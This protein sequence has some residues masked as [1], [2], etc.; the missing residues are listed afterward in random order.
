M[1]VPV[2]GL[3]RAWIAACCWL[4]AGAAAADPPAP[5]LPAAIAALGL[6]AAQQR[7]WNEG[8]A[9]ET[10]ESFQAST[11]RYAALAAAHPESVFLA[12]RIARNHW[13]Y[14]ERLP[15]DAKAERREAFTRS[16]EWAERALAGDPEC[17]ECVFWT[18]ASMGRL[19]TTV[20][21]VSSARMAAPIAALIDRGIA[22]HPTSSDNE[23]NHTMGNLY[24][25][26]S[27]Y[28]RLLPEW[29][30]LDWVIG[31]HG[32]K[33]RALEYIEQALAIA[34]MRI[35][36]HIEH[37]VVLTCLGVERGNAAAL[38]R[39]RRALTHARML[40]HLLGTDAIDQQSAALLLEKPELA[41]GYSRDGFIDLSGLQA[42]EGRAQRGASRAKP[43]PGVQAGAL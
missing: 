6:D 36:Y 15:V 40:P 27:A 7:L 42:S 11:E 1:E 20:G 35:D 41:C 12:W 18:M 23:W 25:A 37:G 24:L 39:G 5:E 21:V 17:G 32:D 33:D 22:L 43:G 8:L 14:G 28:Y 19:A 38:A 4:V 10:R 9:L 34:P 31:V 26:A 2:V 3:A 29:A 30:W 16:H 13:R